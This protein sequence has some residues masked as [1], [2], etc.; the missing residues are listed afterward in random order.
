MG[1]K[2]KISNDLYIPP[3]LIDE[4]LVYSRRYVKKFYIKKKAGNSRRAIYQPSKKL[5]TIQYWLLTNVFEKLPIH[6]SSAAYLKGKSIL[7]NAERHRKNLYFLK[8]DFK[9]FFPSIK[10]RDLDPIIS[11]WHKKSSLDWELTDY[12]RKL[13][14]QSCFDSD[15]SLPIGYPSSPIISNIVMFG[16]DEKIENLLDNRGKYGRAIYTRYADDLVISTDKKDVCKD[17]HNAV[18]KLIDKSVSPELSLNPAKTKMGSSTSGSAMVT[19]LRVCANGHI[20]IHRKQKD[21]IRLLL[22]LCKKRQLKEE[23]Q[24]SLLGHLAYVRYVAPQFYSKLQIKYF[25]EIRRLKYPNE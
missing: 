20:T 24:A 11:T 15:D 23:E 8:M 19:G 14:R 7:S 18:S 3:E 10:W 6:N 17:I 9:D 25:K 21:H 13:I 12:A 2:E 5:K 1:I 4:A 16:L 22:S